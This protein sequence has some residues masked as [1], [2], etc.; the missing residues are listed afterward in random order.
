MYSNLYS[1]IMYFR[2]KQTGVRTDAQI[3]STLYLLID[4][5]TFFDF[6]HER[7]FDECIDVLRKLDCIPLYPDDVEQKVNLLH[8]IPDEVR[9][10]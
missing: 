5:C 2:Y 7:R 6:Y 3:T 10:E 1:I 8:M 4:F 9:I